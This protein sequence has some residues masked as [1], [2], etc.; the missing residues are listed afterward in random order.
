MSKSVEVDQAWLA[1]QQGQ[2]GG[3]VG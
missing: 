3:G 1:G 2:R